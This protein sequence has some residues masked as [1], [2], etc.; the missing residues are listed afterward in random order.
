MLTDKRM[1][2]KR[3]KKI[4]AIKHIIISWVI[5]PVLSMLKE[6]PDDI[7]LESELENCEIND[8]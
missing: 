4:L 5:K 1:S 7:A 8:S 2:P 6:E 3:K